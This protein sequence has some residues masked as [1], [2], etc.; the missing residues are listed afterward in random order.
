MLCGFSKTLEPPLDREFARKVTRIVGRSV[1]KHLKVGLVA[2]ATLALAAAYL[3]SA[4][5]VR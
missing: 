1:G 5:V 3:A 4:T 2:R